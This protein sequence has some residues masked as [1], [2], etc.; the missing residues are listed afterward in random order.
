MSNK[1][2]KENY[3][4]HLKDSVERL[5]ILAHKLSLQA[6]ELEEKGYISTDC[7]YAE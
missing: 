4:K 2:T 5:K 1:V 3:I 6:K 7:Y